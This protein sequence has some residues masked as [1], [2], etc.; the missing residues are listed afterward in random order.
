M[1][2]L[3]IRDKDTEN[4]NPD[5]LSLSILISRDGF[6]YA[7]YNKEPKRFNALV[8]Q[9]CDN[10]EDIAAEFREFVINEKL[11]L[12]KY[13]KVNIVIADHRTTIIPEALFQNSKINE[14][15]NLNFFPTPERVVKFSKL[16][17]SG[18]YLIY[19]V[20]N[21]IIQVLDELFTEYS[22]FPQSHS[23]IESHFTDNKLSDSPLGEKVY[24]QVFHDFCDILILKDSAVVFYNTYTYRTN[25]DLLYYIINIF[26]QLKLSQENA[27]LVFSGF[28]ETDNLAVLNLRKF[29]SQVYFESQNTDYK[30]FYKFQETSPHYYYNFLNIISCE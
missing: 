22:L 17:K 10:M 8:S 5:D 2:N 29:V 24:V 21:D 30:Y 18:N 1:K 6:S 9:A 12:G 26:D 15:Y 16:D 4:I 19:S 14:I 28:I 11:N 13:Q 20:D 27:K 25:N 3:C 23:F 7:L